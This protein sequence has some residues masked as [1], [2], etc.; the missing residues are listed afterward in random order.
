MVTFV[1][2]LNTYTSTFLPN[3]IVEINDSAVTESFPKEINFNPPIQL[4]RSASFTVSSGVVNPS[5]GSIYKPTGSLAQLSGSGYILNFKVFL[6]VNSSIFNIGGGGHGFTVKFALQ[7]SIN[8]GVSWSDLDDHTQYFPGNT[9]FWYEEFYLRH[10]DRS[11]TTSSLYRVAALE[12]GTPVDQYNRP[13]AIF[14][15]G[16][17]Q[18]ED[19]S[20]FQVIQYPASNTG[21]VT[22][23][24]MT[25]SN[26]NLLFA[27]KGNEINTFGLNDVWGQKQQNIENSGFDP[28]V[29]DFEPQ[30]GDEI[31]FGGVEVQSYTITQ[32][33]QSVTQL[34]AGN[35]NALTLVLDR[36]ISNTIN[37]DYFLIRRYIT[38]PGNIILDISKPA[39]QTSDGVLIPEFLG[40]KA[41]ETKEK[42]ISLL[43]TQS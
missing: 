30:A 13:V 18:V 31:R 39:G 35:Y 20:Y 16:V 15:S 10:T 11:A 21:P 38:D 6:R 29:Y 14:G 2:S 23:F 4:G 5:T 17:I 37:T 40:E 32:V 28:I 42:I 36:Q 7:K 9:S 33:S 41:T 34:G 27:K 19:S 12:R 22:Q 1:P 24:W 43:R 8:K 25:G 3:R 26:S